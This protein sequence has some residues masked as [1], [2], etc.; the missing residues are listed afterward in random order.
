MSHRLPAPLGEVIDRSSAISFTW[1]GKKLQGFE[2]DT[3]ASALLANGEHILGRS[4]K[5]HRPRGVLTADFWDPNTTVQVDDEPN[6]RASH[7]KLADGMAVSAQN[8]WPSLKFDVKAANGLVG[9]F[10]TA[11]FYYK[12]FMK[13]AKL[14][15]AYEHVLAKFAPGGSV[16]LDTPHGRYDKR[17]AHPDV[18]VAGGGPSGMAAALAA[19]EAGSSV[20]LVE[21]EHQLG[22]HLLW[23]SDDDRAAAN[24]LAAACAAAGVEILTNSTVAGRYEDNWISISQRSHPGV[25][26]RL[27]K[28]RAKTLVVQPARSSV[29]TCS[30][31]TIFPA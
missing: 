16:D 2:G 3:I 27:I 15:P 31:A 14:W 18:V 7:R 4:M 1:N 13:P 25:I 21:H 20:M 22:G 10:L 11:G 9:R 12:T 17:H 23:G 19:A 24:E 5:Y 28:A 30:R 8:V 29:R 6:V 26:E